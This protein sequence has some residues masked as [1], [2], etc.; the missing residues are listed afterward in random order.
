MTAAEFDISGAG[1]SR[2]SNNLVGTINTNGM[3]N[4]VWIKAKTSAGTIGM[5]IRKGD[6]AVTSQLVSVTTEWV[7]YSIYDAGGAGGFTAI[8][9]Y[10]NRNF[11]GTCFNYY[12]WHPMLE[13]AT[14]NTAS[15]Y[16]PTTTAAASQGS[17]PKAWLF[18]GTDDRLN[19]SG[20]VFQ[21]SDDHF[22]VACAKPLSAAASNDIFTQRNT[23]STNAICPIVRYD[24]DS[25]FKALWRDDAATLVVKS[26]NSTS[27]LGTT[28]VIAARKSGNNK[29]LRVNGVVQS[30]VDT[31]VL[32]AT[33]L[34]SA[35]IGC[36]VSTTNTG[37][38]NGP[39]CGVIAGK[40]TITEAEILVLEKYLGSLGGL[41]I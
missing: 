11:G 17:R 8:Q 34:N 39:I 14:S 26:A 23:A 32:G 20:P 27:S 7:R 24:T 1:D 29:S 41:N 33:T 30:T 2:I 22:V 25:K 21:M 36:T 15:A 4:S 5:G 9:Y 38:F 18:D 19:L 6:G 10:G 3:C 40:G 37:F 35:T 31:T 13:L 12:V 16:V 28:A